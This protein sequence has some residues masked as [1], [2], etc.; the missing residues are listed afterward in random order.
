MFRIITWNPEGTHD[1][2]HCIG[3]EYER[4]MA[5]TNSAVS[6]NIEEYHIVKD[7]MYAGG[8]EYNYELPVTVVF[9]TDTECQVLKHDYFT[10]HSLP[11]DEA[12]LEA[13]LEAYRQSVL[14]KD[15]VRVQGSFGEAYMSKTGKVLHVNEDSQHEWVMSEFNKI[16]EFDVEEYKH[17]WGADWLND[18]INI[19]HIGWWNVDGSYEN[20][21]NPR[22]DTLTHMVEEGM[23]VEGKDINKLLKV[24]EALTQG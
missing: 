6:F 21:W 14:I 11:K 18:G 4:I 22:L 5:G 9:D 23:V 7:A 15:A 1:D 2:G 16:A 13:L 12:E 24:A 10:T 19:N 17:F 3:R 8:Y 20:C